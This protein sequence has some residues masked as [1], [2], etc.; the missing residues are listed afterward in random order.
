MNIFLD[1]ILPALT[2]TTAIVTILLLFYQSTKQRKLD[3]LER[4]QLEKMREY[5]ESQIYALNNKMI[6]NP[7]RWKDT[8]YLV[9]DP[10]ISSSDDYFN[11]KDVQYSS[12]LK[13][14]GLNPSDLNIIKDAVF[15][16]TPFHKE[17]EETFE[18]IRQI[19]N[20]VGLRGQRSDEFVDFNEIFPQIV[21]M[22]ATSRLIIAN[23]DGRNPNVFYELGI[24]HAMGKPTIMIAKSLNEVPFDLQSKTVIIY[25]DYDELKERLSIAMTKLIIN[26]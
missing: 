17:M 13:S 24:A 5:Y 12:F 19:C 1:I 20:R 15:V 16:L 23:L 8:N 9:T 22:I 11:Q 3:K 6:A 18:V 4:V 21:K 14:V 10:R 2:V 25:K 7:T 26:N